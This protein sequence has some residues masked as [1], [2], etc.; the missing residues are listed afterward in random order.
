[1][2][3]AARALR[4]RARVDVRQRAEFLVTTARRFIV[5]RSEAAQIPAVPC[6]ALHPKVA[7]NCQ[8]KE[9]T[10]GSVSYV[11]V[12]PPTYYLFVGGPTRLFSN[13]VSGLRAGRIAGALVCLALLGFALL[14][15]WRP[16]RPNLGLVLGITPMTLYLAGSVN[17][18]ALEVC[19]AVAFAAVWVQVFKRGMTGWLAVASLVIGGL[20]AWSRPLGALWVMAAMLFV[21][22]M[23]GREQCVAFLRQR[24]NALVTVGLAVLTGSAVAYTV[25]AG[26]GAPH[27]RG[28]LDPIVSGAI[29]NLGLFI[30]QQIGIFGWRDARQPTL[31]YAVWIM[32]TLAVIGA[33]YWV[34]RP[35]IRVIIIGMLIAYF[36][37]TVALAVEYS[38]TGF[39]FEARYILP[40]WSVVMIV[41]G[42]EL[43]D[44]TF[45]WRSRAGG[46]L[47]GVTGS[48][49][50]L[51]NAVALLADERRFAVG[52]HGA[53]LFWRH[54]L[55]SPPG[56]WWPWLA[57]M[58]VG[59]VLV[60]VWT[61]IGMRNLAAGNR[62]HEAMA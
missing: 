12:Y 10:F 61:A 44:G 51:V 56:G 5:P 11:G 21:A 35:R 22:V 1:V 52:A 43:A 32:A 48:T 27:R 6:F 31:A 20:C 34:S 46:A 8:S 28:G 19:S 62:P 23:R 41:I 47:L 14:I 2:N 59:T 57:L 55:W 13:P 40:L 58:L 42:N 38:G 26:F 49:F 16:A 30:I 33:A 18:S 7:A 15:S 3:G 54:P 9:G 50:A 39:R 29:K 4:L 53:L 36:V 45:R 25:I 60:L 17:A 24:R 37:G